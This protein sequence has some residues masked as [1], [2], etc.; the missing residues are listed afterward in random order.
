MYAD[1]AAFKDPSL[2]TG[3]VSLSRAA[4]VEKYQGLQQAF[5]DLRDEVVQ[6]YP[7]GDKHIVVEFV[8]YGKSDDG[9]E[10]ELP[11]CTIFTVDNGKITADFTYYDNGGEESEG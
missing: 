9:F 2:G 4:F 5:P 3:V 7:S 10:L 11:V 1:N 6:V 8:S